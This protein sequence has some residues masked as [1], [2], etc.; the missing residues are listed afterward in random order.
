M[1]DLYREVQQGLAARRGEWPRIA[2]DL[3]PDVSYSWI[4][5]VG[6]DDYESAPSYKKLRL[7]QTYLLTGRR[8]KAEK[9]RKVAA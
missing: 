3:K 4:S 8:S 5:K 7:V 2:D 1:D 6:N 9:R